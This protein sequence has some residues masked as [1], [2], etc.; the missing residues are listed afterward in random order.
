M[1]CLLVFDAQDPHPPPVD[2]P[3][4]RSLAVIENDRT[5]GPAG[6]LNAGLL[7][8]SGDLVAICDDDD[9]WLQR[10]LRIQVETLRGLP[11]TIVVSCGIHLLDGRTHTRMP[12]SEPIGFHDLLRSRHREIHTSTLL[13]RRE[14][15]LEEVG[16]FD[17]QIPASFAED[18]DWVLRAARVAPVVGVPYALVRVHLQD[19][20]FAQRWEGIARAFIYLLDK[21]PQF[22]QEPRGLARVRGQI[23]I[24]LAAAGR[25]EEARMWASRCR[26]A[27]WR[28]PRGYLAPLMA[29]GIL[30]PKTY[31]RLGRAAGRGI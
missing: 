28:Q 24:G 6:A 16:P 25:G 17:E 19:S 2:L 22:A 21:Y 15:C 23:A 8:A 27:D 18:Y 30:T 3:R 13:L 5:P 9:E 11:E 4:N 1:E 10:K 26:R 14:R 20:Y 12:P 31:V 7:R 29:R